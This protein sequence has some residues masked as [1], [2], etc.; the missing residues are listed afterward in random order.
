M[1]KLARLNLA[2]DEEEKYAKQLSGILDYVDQLKNMP[3]GE[4]LTDSEAFHSLGELRLDQTDGG[5][6]QQ[7]IIGAAPTKKGDLL[8][9]PGVFE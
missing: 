3:G 4:A 7:Q 8:S 1:A 5:R 2:P 6:H 9:V